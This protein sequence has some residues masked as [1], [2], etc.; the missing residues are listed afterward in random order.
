MGDKSPKNT[1]K[2]KKQKADKKSKGSVKVA[3]PERPEIEANL[4]G[5][6]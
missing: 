1:T 5:S 6:R 3:P 4:A 2:G